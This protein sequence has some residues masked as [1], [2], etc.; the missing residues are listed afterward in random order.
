MGEL[1]FLKLG[2]SLITDKTGVEA[3]RPGVLA[4]VAGEVQEVLSKRPDLHLVLGHGSGSFGHVPAAKYGTR[5]GVRLPEEWRGFADVSD[6]AARLNAIVRESFLQA[7]VP[8]L[9]LQPSATV[10]CRDGT[11]LALETGPVRAAL[12][13]HLIPLVY[14]DVAFDDERGGTIVSTEELL[15]T[16]VPEFHPTWL[17]LAGQTGGVYDGQGKIIP[18]ITPAN[19]REIRGAL[20]GSGGTDVTGGMAS[21]VRT[22]LDLVQDHQE[23]SIRIFSG[24]QPGC[25]RDVLLYPEDETGTIIR[26]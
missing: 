16:L 4:R 1:I 5:R 25:L 21:K 6:A 12:Q 17:L 19:F 10:R 14:G 11:I 13:A 3:L 26:S 9:T 2:G 20:G 7:G 15:A 8:V 23:L 22:M 18:S 24:L